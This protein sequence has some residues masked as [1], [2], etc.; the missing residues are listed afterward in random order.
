MPS[1]ISC[2]AWHFVSS[3]ASRR[4]TRESWPCALRRHRRLAW[5]RM[6]RQ[7]K[8]LVQSSNCWA[9][10]IAAHERKE[11]AEIL[12]QS[13]INRAVR[14]PNPLGSTSRVLDRPP[15]RTSL[16]AHRPR[17]LAWARYRTPPAASARFALPCARLCPRVKD[18]DFLPT[19]PGS[20][21]AEPQ[22]RYTISP[23]HAAHRRSC[24]RRSH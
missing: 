3:R 19:A 9:E 23:A 2:R 24:E 14:C 13:I 10:S 6:A 7:A 12:Y 22:L 5:R 18:L 4:R 15:P 11:P 16:L 1:N 20:E 8:A 17:F 21:E